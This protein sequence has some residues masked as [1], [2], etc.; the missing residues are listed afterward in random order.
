MWLKLT[1]EQSVTRLD[2]IPGVNR[3]VAEIILAEVGTDMSKFKDAQHLAS[4]AGLCPG[5]R[6]SAGKRLS[7]KTRKGNSALRR[8]LAEAGNAAAKTK[9]SYLGVQFQ[10]IAQR[11]GHKIAVIAVAHSILK[12]V[13]YMLSR[14]EEYQDLG[15]EHYNQRSENEGGQSRKEKRLVRSLEQLGYEVKLSKDKDKAKTVSLVN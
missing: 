3:R 15:L 12:I 4:W 6:E 7:G 1:F 5:N 10:R 2:E 11:R 13:Y 9:R 8:V 14:E